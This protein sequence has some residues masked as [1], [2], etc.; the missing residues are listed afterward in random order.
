MAE[1][2]PIASPTTPP[3]ED[4]YDP[5]QEFN[6]VQGRSAVRNPYPEFEELRN[7]CPVQKIDMRQLLGNE[8][9]I[10]PDVVLEVYAA[11]NHEAASEVLRDPHRFTSR[12]Y[13][14]SM[15]QVFGHSILEMD[16]PEHT[17][18]RALIQHA[19]TKRA[20]DRWERELV[21]PVVHGLIDRFIERGSADLVRELTFPFPVAV[22]AGMIGV[23]KDQHQNFHR[24]AVELISV[25]FARE[26]GVAAS[27]KLGNLFAEIL[28]DRRKQPRDDLTSVLAHAEI[29]GSKLS[30][31]DIFAFLRLLAPA[32]AETTYRSSSNLLLALL[33]HP[34]Q[35]EALRQDRS[36]IPQA[37]DEG[38]RW[39]CPLTG[40]MRIATA[41][42]EVAGAKLPAGALVNVNLG[43]ANHDDARYEDPERFDIFR[44]RKQ[45]LAF[46]SGPHTCLGMHLALMETRVVLEA[47]LDRLANLQLDSEAQDIHIGGVIFR[48]PAALPVRFDT[49][50]VRA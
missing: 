37:I 41:E 21:G 28:A 33:T 25:Q 26:R 29:D 2:H 10:P 3:L 34:S 7:R 19:F 15:G 36:L 8:F 1:Q 44:P 14:M 31:A 50:K 42:T 22:I 24:W 6:R 46:A 20:L 30:D 32:G 18:Y 9:P 12:G 38:L 47:I 11:L 45:H 39:E 48:S 43:A 49:G 40:I 4:D 16:P 27:E 35:L 5:F 23:P 17:R 13:A